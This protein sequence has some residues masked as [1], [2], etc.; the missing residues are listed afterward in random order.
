MNEVMSDVRNPYP[1]M[2]MQLV[3]VT[4]PIGDARREW[5]THRELIELEGVTCRGGSTKTDRQRMIDTR[6]LASV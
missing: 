6:V 2:A 1:L 3:H 4:C 5:L